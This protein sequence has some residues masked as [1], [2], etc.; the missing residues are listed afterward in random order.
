[1]SVRLFGLRDHQDEV[2]QVSKPGKE[3]ERERGKRERATDGANEED[4]VLLN[5]NASKSGRLPLVEKDAIYL[6]SH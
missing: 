6:H 1:M 3:K 5:S 4:R 2:E